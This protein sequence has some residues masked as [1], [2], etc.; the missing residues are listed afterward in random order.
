MHIPPS[1][2]VWQ[3]QIPLKKYL[4]PIFNILQLYA[5]FQKIVERFH[6]NPAVPPNSDV[7]E[8]F[9][10]LSESP[11]RIRVVYHLEKN[12]VT[13]SSREFVVPPSSRELTFNPGMSS[14]YQVSQLEVIEVTST[15]P[16]PYY[17]ETPLKKEHLCSLP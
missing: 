10:L 7:A 12:R 14:A 15:T 2:F 4:F 5:N 8:R 9:F 13:R 17:S 3:Y 6:R 16:L 11:S 1:T